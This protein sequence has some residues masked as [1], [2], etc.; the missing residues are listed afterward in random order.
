MKKLN[1]LLLLIFLV[2]C[3]KSK[4]ASWRVK[5]MRFTTTEDIINLKTTEEGTTALYIA[6]E[7]NQTDIVRH[8][9]AKGAQIDVQNR[10]GQTPLYVATVRRNYDVVKLL[11]DNGART[12]IR[13]KQGTTALHIAARWDSTTIVEEL[14][15]RHTNA[16][17]RDKDGNTPLHLAAKWG[18]ITAAE[19]LLA[20]GTPVN[21]INKRGDTPLHLIARERYQVTIDLAHT[22]FKCKTL[23][24]SSDSLMYT[25]V[26]QR[27]GNKVVNKEARTTLSVTSRRYDLAIVKILLKAGAAIDPLNHDGHTPQDLAAKS[28]NSQI[29]EYLK[30]EMQNKEEVQRAAISVPEK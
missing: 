1:I 25:P 8:L 13:D 3:S 10:F 30:N 18:C 2:S 15:A 20:A 21:V 5:N 28:G 14:L 6:A 9:L 24:S 23:F 26:A 29:V 19:R 4:V 11:L 27:S 17:I 22:L 7:E 12:D 16:E